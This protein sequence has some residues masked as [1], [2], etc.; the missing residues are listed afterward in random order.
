LVDVGDGISFV[1]ESLM[2]RFSIRRYVLA[3]IL[4]FLGALPQQRLYAQGG[5]H[6]FPEAAP[7]I[8]D[9]IDGQIASYWQ[10]QGGLSL[11]GYPITSAREEVNHDDGKTHLTQWFQ[12]NRFELHPEN[13]PPYDVL[14]GRLGDD[15]LRQ[16]GRD[17]RSEPRADGPQARCLWF[18]QTGH[19]VCDQGTGLGFKTYWQTRGLADRRLNKYNRSLALFGLP[20]TEAREEVSQTDGQTYLTQWFE[21]VRFEWHP[22]ESDQFKVLL[23]LLGS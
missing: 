19:N 17:W 16:L 9:C 6:C 18:A 10:Q 1:K 3:S 13:K 20:L 15:R 11:F 5:Q 23:G 4:V 12:R 2:N 7:V 8:V 14:L 21:R 22:Q